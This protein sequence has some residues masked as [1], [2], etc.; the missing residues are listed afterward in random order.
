M[1][2]NSEAP[3]SRWKITP[4][5]SHTPKGPTV[6]RFPPPS[7]DIF[8]IEANFVN[9]VLSDSWTAMQT[10]SW[11][12]SFF[13]GIHVSMQFVCVFAPCGSIIPMKYCTARKSKCL[14]FCFAGTAPFVFM[15][16]F[17][18]PL[19]SY[20]VCNRPPDDQ[21]AHWWCHWA[22]PTPQLRGD[23]TVSMVTVQFGGTSQTFIQTSNKT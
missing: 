10:I 13:L 16:K 11:K 1:G 7:A 8:K 18:R 19:W 2:T 9:D 4:C 12:L 17:P 23:V 22:L 14:R 21:S 5:T 20:V 3:P 15:P 6:I